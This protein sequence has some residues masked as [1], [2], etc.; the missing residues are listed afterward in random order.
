M[1]SLGKAFAYFS[2][3]STIT[4]TSAIANVRP[5]QCT[6]PGQVIDQV[7]LGRQGVSSSQSIRRNGTASGTTQLSTKTLSFRNETY[8]TLRTRTCDRT[9]YQR[10]ARICNP[11]RDPRGAAGRG[12]HTFREL[13][14]QNSEFQKAELVT[15]IMT[16]ET[17]APT[18][19][20]AFYIAKHFHKISQEAKIPTTF[21][22]FV[23]ELAAVAEQSETDAPSLYDELAALWLAQ[24]DEGPKN[25][26]SRLGFVQKGDM[27]IT[28]S[29]NSAAINRLLQVNSAYNIQRLLR[30]D[31]TV[32]YFVSQSF[33]EYAAQQRP[34]GNWDYFK[35]LMQD[36]LQKQHITAQIYNRVVV[37]REMETRTS[38]GMELSVIR[39]V[40]QQVT[41]H[42]NKINTRNN[43]VDVEYVD[44]K[45]S[46]STERSILLSNEQETITV[47]ANGMARPSV[48]VTNK[49]NA[50]SSDITKEGSDYEITL[51]GSRK[52]VDVS[53]STVEA[54]LRFNGRT[55]QAV[56]SHPLVKNMA[57]YKLVVE[58]YKD[59]CCW[60]DQKKYTA[61]L[62]VGADGV[63]NI[64]FNAVRGDRYYIKY[65]LQISGSSVYSNGT[66]R[67]RQ[68][69]KITKK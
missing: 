43:K 24:A 15:N 49:Y 20:A 16:T 17:E 69:N 26:R 11:V 1:V 34:E 6:V 52:K 44:T 19:D 41:D 58:L 18:S 10:P 51:T 40:I 30:V 23:D 61:T 68:S 39:C 54:S 48:T 31:S 50:Y 59:F 2:L 60:V 32:A 29:T 36:A 47:T 12:N 21:D 55:F 25:L 22:E 13:F 7:K 28:D 35:K 62:N 4:L 46:V 66:T 53:G 33:R 5:D 63:V 65:K 9:P 8:D 45:V 27:T 14:G 37:Y 67:Q 38:L 56:V 57:T 3:L 64:P 42:Y